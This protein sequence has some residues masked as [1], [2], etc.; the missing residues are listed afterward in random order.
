[1]DKAIIFVTGMDP[2]KGSG[3][4]SSYIRSHGRAAQA[5]GYEPHIF[6]LS[7][8]DEVVSADFGFVH[9]TYTPFRS[10][11]ILRIRPD[12]QGSFIKNW[13]ASLIYT[14][15]FIPFNESRLA[16][17]IINYLKG[18]PGPHL[19]HGFHNWGCVGL[20]VREQLNG[21]G[22]VVKVINSFYTTGENEAR[23][24]LIGT[25]KSG[26]RLQ[27]AFQSIE[28]LWI[29]TV[30][31]F[32]ERRAYKNSDLVL[33]NYESV[34][35]L[36][37]QKHGAGAETR[38]CPYTSEI[39]LTGIADPEGADLESAPVS[40]VPLIL[41]VSR[42]DPRKGLD[43]LI[44]ALADLKQRGVAYRA[45]L[46]SGGSM[47][48]SH[49]KLADLSRLTDLHFTGWVER[50]A[51][52]FKNVDIFV[53]PSIQEGSGSVS[54]LEAMQH[55]LAIVASDI[56]GIP[57]DVTNEESA[58][59]IPPG[60]PAELSKALERLISDDGL[61]TRLGQA[62]RKRYLENHAPQVFIEALRGIYNKFR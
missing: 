19:I 2:I 48:E 44:R 18:N 35:R 45:C 62:A 36:F 47:L 61:R 57:E 26:T 37:K 17:S 50:V 25:F 59:L 43:V 23:L 38:K 39:A 54:M 5:A 22:I 31:A 60:D 11:G 24:K 4:G 15:H 12:S 52:Y 28:W 14:G 27:M 58:L 3:G 21:S 33:V 55:G 10:R 16:K 1:M 41:T 20:K 6:C 49:K 9:R 34:R 7:D 13:V 42:H 56:D 46:T 53:L 32:Y 8:R 40:A 29:A 51:P 30:A